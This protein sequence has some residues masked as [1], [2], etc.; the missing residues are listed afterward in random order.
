MARKVDGPTFRVDGPSFRVCLL[1]DIQ[2]KVDGLNGHCVIIGRPKMG[3][4]Q[5]ERPE[6]RNLLDRP[7]QNCLVKV[8]S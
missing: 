2:L 6:G 4:K 1:T 5:L 3:R 7:T 8:R